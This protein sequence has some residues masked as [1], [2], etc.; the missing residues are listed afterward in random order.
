MNTGTNTEFN[1]NLWNNKSTLIKDIW[2]AS[3]PL[4]LTLALYSTT[5]GMVIAYLEGELFSGNLN[6]DI[7]LI[8]LVTVAGVAVQTATNFINDYFECEIEY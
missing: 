3:R 7:W 6:Y 8:F 4:S 1:N 2:R 5:I